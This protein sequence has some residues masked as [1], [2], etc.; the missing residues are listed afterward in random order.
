M[1][2]SKPQ[3]GVDGTVDPDQDDPAQAWRQ[4]TRWL[5]NDVPRRAEIELESDDNNQSVAIIVRARDESYL[6]LDNASVQLT[7]TPPSGESF[8]LTPEMDE[9]EQGAYRAVCW[10]QDPGGYRVETNVKS[11]DGTVVGSDVAGWTAQPAATEL[12]NLQTNRE[13]LRRIAEDTGGELVIDTDLD[14]FAAQLPTR[15]VPVSETWVY[16]IWHRPWVMIAAML[17]LCGEWGL[18]RLRGLA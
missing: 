13:L 10:S 8:A 18:R 9:S 6:P 17:C 16:P 7:I 4:L 5:V 2:R 14:R 1:R 15:E 11:A 12:A 3:Q